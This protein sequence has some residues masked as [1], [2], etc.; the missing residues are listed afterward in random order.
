MTVV[1][2]P[3]D[4]AKT[5]RTELERAAFHASCFLAGLGARDVTSPVDADLLVADLVV[6]GRVGHGATIPRTGRDRLIHGTISSG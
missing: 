2:S 3:G 4:P 6:C 1:P 5:G